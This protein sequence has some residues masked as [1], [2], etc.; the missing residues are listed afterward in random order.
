[1]SPSDLEL[2]EQHQYFWH[3]RRVAGVTSV[4]SSLGLYPGAQ[5]F[6]EESRQ[7]GTA[8]H[9]AV[10]LW[11]ED[12]LDESSVSSVVR[13]YL[14]AAVSFLNH[15][16]GSDRRGAIEK[17]VFSEPH[18]YAGTLDLHAETF[19]EDSVIDWKS[20]AISDVTGLQLAAYDTAL[21]GGK[22]RRRI[23]V[24]L[25]PDGTYR[26]QTF[27]DP[28]DYPRWL[29]ALGLYRRYIEPHEKKEESNAA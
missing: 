6:T 15:A 21:G 3:G 17:R 19:G 18:L 7:R 11:L 24:Q 14:D 10:Q 28:T 27:A 29:N 23:G 22:R 16:L 5:F 2:N 20:G 4:L 25:R 9:L 8:V 12:D 26:M 13:P 1:M